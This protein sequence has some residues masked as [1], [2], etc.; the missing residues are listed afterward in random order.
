MSPLQEAPATGHRRRARLPVVERRRRAVSAHAPGDRRQCGHRAAALPG[1][2][3]AEHLHGPGTRPGR[4][5][6]ADLRLSSKEGVMD[7][8][9]SAPVRF[10]VRAIGWCLL[11]LTVVLGV[12]LLM[13]VGI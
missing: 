12:Y 4:H 3:A 5:Q 11:I 13:A 1:P 2:A 9:K 7:I 10:I 8:S 6:R